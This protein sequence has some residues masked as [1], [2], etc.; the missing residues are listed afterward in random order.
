MY[1]QGLCSEADTYR[2]DLPYKDTLEALAY[3]VNNTGAKV[4]LSS[5]WRHNPDNILL[6]NNLFKPY[7]FQIY[8]K[9]CDGVSI[10]AVEK[11]GFDSNMVYDYSTMYDGHPSKPYTTDRGAEIAK[12]LFTHS[13]VESFV[14]L[15][16]DVED[17]RPYFKKEHVKT[18]FYKDALDMDCARKAVEILMK[19]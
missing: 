3:I 2:W 4:V 5:S 11:M 9:T 13:D 17:I 1:K 7:G 6:L 18:D 8:D 16:D 10:E 19:K 14:I 12:W 15:D